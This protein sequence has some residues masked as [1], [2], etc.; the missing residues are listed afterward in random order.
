MQALP[1]TD[2]G[3]GYQ[4][5]SFRFNGRAL[6]LRYPHDDQ[7]PRGKWRDSGFGHAMTVANRI[8]VLDEDVDLPQYWTGRVTDETLCN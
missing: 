3:D 7:Q 4:E 5:A 1:P 8:L 2:T 6:V